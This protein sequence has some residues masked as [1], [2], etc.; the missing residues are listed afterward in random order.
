MGYVNK[1][2]DIEIRKQLTRVY[3]SFSPFE[4]WMAVK[5][6]IVIGY[7]SRR[8]NSGRL[9]QDVQASSAVGMR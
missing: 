9:T 4:R 8:R 6:L 7:S 2:Q 3:S 1:K 5:P